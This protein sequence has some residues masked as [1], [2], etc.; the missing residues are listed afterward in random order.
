MVVGADGQLPLPWL[1]APLAA[2]LAQQ[3]AHA[4]LLHG[5]AGAGA[6]A[7][8]LTLA[9][10]WL[11]EST[12]PV[13]PCGRCTACHLVQSH[14]HP[15]LL[16]LL[17]ESMRQPLGWPLRDDKPEGDGEGAGKRKPSRQIRIDEIRSAIDWIVK[18]SSRGVAKVLVLHPAEAMNLQS[19]S[20]LLKTL[21]E[22]PAGTR[23]LLSASD[24][25]RLLPTVRS[26]CQRLALAAPP[27]DQAI[28]WLAGQ[29]VKDGDVLLRAAAGRPLDALAMAQAGIDARAWSALPAA[30]AAGQG[31]A[32]AGWAVPQVVDALH[33]LC[34]D[35]MAMAAGGSPLYFSAAAMP[36][37]VQL[38][39]LVRWA[40][41]LA[42][43]AR[44]EDH[45]WNDGLLVD[46]LV[47]Q[48]RTALAPDASRRPARPLATLGS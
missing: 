19:A 22:P 10:A 20:A 2:A 44:H 15:D 27:T 36:A 13:K 28:D 5:A 23:L 11:C 31:A 39:E 4:L 33:K 7:F 17:P 1:A 34:H 38:P 24:P 29:G 46:A 42:R 12:A 32:F 18:T 14:V 47:S 45:G 40:D 48:G 35:A 25:E 26:R 21:E 8:S 37:P 43:V 41:S 6:L 9:Q 30:V 16:V 3:R